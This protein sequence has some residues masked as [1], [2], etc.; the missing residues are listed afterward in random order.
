MPVCLLWPPLPTKHEL[1]SDRMVAGTSNLPMVC[2][3]AATAFSEVVSLNNAAPVTHLEASS[4][5]VIRFRSFMRGSF[6]TCQP[7]CHM[8]LEY[9]R[10]YLTHLR[11][12]DFAGGVDDQIVGFHYRVY[13]R[14]AYV[15]SLLLEHLGHPAPS[16]FLLQMGQGSSADR[17]GARYAQ[18]P[19]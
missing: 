4:R 8:A 19:S 11:F 10:S 5:Y 1:L 18:S 6:I 15:M 7:V 13:A 2:R 3:S 16:G 12:L 9:R 14:A 17:R